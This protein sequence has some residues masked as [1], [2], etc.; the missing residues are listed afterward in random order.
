MKWRKWLM[1]KTGK[2]GNV[3]FPNKF[4]SDSLENFN[5]YLKWCVG[6]STDELSKGK[7]SRL[8]KIYFAGP[9][10]DTRANELYNSCYKICKIFKNNYDIYFPREE[11]SNDTPKDAFMNNV[12]HIRNS[13]II[14]AMVS[15]KDVGT[16]WEIGMA[17]ALN[18]EIYLLGYDETTFLSHTNVM[19][20]FTGKCFTLNKL[21][22]FLNN[23]MKPKDFV[24]IENVWEGIE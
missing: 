11:P 17:Y 2:T 24:T 21:G 16:A 3:R 10:F 15:R 14:I 7:K 19:L 5:D 9:W 8:P 13:D 1:S 6:E 23:D 12:A 20:A 18:K 22:K 4:D